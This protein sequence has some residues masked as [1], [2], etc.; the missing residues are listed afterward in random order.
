MAH[1]AIGTIIARKKPKLPTHGAWSKI[2]RQILGTPQV[3]QIQGTRFD[4]SSLAGNC[5]VI[6]ISKEQLIRFI[7]F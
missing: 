3:P 2:M 7:F 6:F 4:I 1:R 5:V